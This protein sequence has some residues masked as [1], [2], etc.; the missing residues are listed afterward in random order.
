MDAAES[1][2]ALLVSGQDDLTGSWGAC[3]KELCFL[4]P[5]GVCYEC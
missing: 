2:D 4:V 3:F 5:N 1:M